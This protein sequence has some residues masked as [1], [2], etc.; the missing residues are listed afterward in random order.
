MR[1]CAALLLAAAPLAL[2]AFQP[3]AKLSVS[4]AEVVVTESAEATLRIF[5][6]KPFQW[7][8]SIRA[9]FIPEGSRLTM[10]RAQVPLDGKDAWR[11]TV[12]VPVKAESAGVQTLG[13]VIVSIPT[14]VGFFGSR[15]F[16]IRTGTVELKVLAPPE[17]GRPASYCGAISS[18]FRATA[19]LDTNLCTAGDPLLFTLEISGATDS[20]MVYAPPVGGAFRG[21]PFKLD[22][23]SLKTE[24]LA[25][26]KRFSWRV[27]AV[28][29][30]TV[31]FPPIEVSFF[32]A[33]SR[34]YRT[35]R[36]DPIPIQ[37]RAGEQAALGA[38]DEAGG[39]TDE[40]PRPDGL[41]LPFVPKS[42]TLKHALSLA[43]RAE[44]EADFAAAASRYDE[45]VGSLGDGGKA[46]AADG[47]QFAAVHY[48]NLGALYLMAGKPRE[49]LKAYGKAELIDG[50]TAGTERGVRAA[51]A[52]IRNDPRAELPLP[53]MM[54][55]FWFR[56]ALKGRIAFSLCALLAFVLLFALALRA[57]RKLSVLAFIVGAAASAQAWPFGGRDPFAGFFD[58]MPSMRRMNMGGDVC[59]IRAKS[60]FGST[61]MMVGEPVDLAVMVEPGSVRIEPGSVKVEADI[62]GERTVGN[63]RSDSPNVYKMR[64]TFLEPGT[65]EVGVAVSGVYSGTYCVTNGNMISS[66]HVMNQPFKI[67]LK[68]ARITV[69]PLPAHMRPDDFR[70]AVGRS[71][72]MKQTLSQDKVHPGDL[73]TAEYR[74]D[75]DG[76]CPSN[77]ELRV[78]NLSREFKAYEVKEVARD[79]KSV[80]W[81]QI[82]VPRTTEA[83][84][85]ALVSLSF[86]NLRTRRYE[87]AAAAPQ[88]LTF[89]SAKAASTE[90]TH[91]MV[92]ESATM[93]EGKGG[94]GG[95]V[96]LRFAP[97][98]KSP[99][100]V[101]VPAGTETRETGRYNGWRRLESP[102]GAGWTK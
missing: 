78:E 50:A 91:V 81:R 83:T 24:T 47:A 42:F 25:A 21:S 99:V 101:T 28:K 70:G 30:G 34:A 57:G 38:L 14:S 11:Y 77:A 6:P 53:R 69:K 10:E 90:N 44:S 97:S 2:C 12:K 9:N 43:F 8:P 85:T 29:A 74:L 63:L 46:D 13:P 79:A 58:D 89:V 1:S 72:R 20:A 100:V 98:V 49:A 45:F 56:L 54:F 51:V 17:D 41:D 84:N 35:I 93:A 40:F 64:I 37:V 19:T 16:D 86:Y 94:E 32:D 65:N 102:R 55:P 3:Y 4:P 39:E 15:T 36:T 66:G 59:P 33:K 67:R 95:A 5:M 92:N 61:V 76:Y 75:F 31:E 62:P 27:R 52:R 22:K 71:F 68:P 73:V 23:A 96:V 80:T 82:L 60:W 88:K 26:S 7:N 87:R 18:D 48:A